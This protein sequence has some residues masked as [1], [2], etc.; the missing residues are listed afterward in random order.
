MPE[1]GELI[2]RFAENMQRS[3]EDQKWVAANT[4]IIIA[5]QY[6]CA[7]MSYDR[8]RF[9]AMDQAIKKNAG[10]FTAL[11][12]D[13]RCCLSAFVLTKG[14]DESAADELFENYRKLV[15][16]GFLRQQQ[17]YMAAALLLDKEAAEE[18]LSK[19]IRLYTLLK[20]R[21]FLL[22]NKG[23]VSLILLLATRDE[24]ETVLVD[25]EEFYFDRLNRYGFHK[26]NDLQTL[27]C[28]L[29][30]SS[31]GSSE[32]LADKCVAIKSDVQARRLRLA[33]NCYPIYGILALLPDENHTVDE[34]AALYQKLREKKFS[35]FIDKNFYFQTAASLYAQFMF[36][37]KGNGMA[38]PGLIAMADHLIRIQEAA[39]AAAIA[40]STSAVIA[41]GSSNGS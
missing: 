38:D 28:L 10:W 15:K 26:N 7:G 33:V 19:A 2:E 4:R 22:T 12:R 31:D 5:T 16:A 25:R 23:D 17:T 21:H 35:H 27:S 36:S 14:K 11:T 34:V 24:S 6:T 40:A 29:A 39:Q 37:S 20:K 9:R 30:F 13:I 18:T 8:D 41:D 1:M 3:A 32:Q